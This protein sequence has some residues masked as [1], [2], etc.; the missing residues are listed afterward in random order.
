MKWQI[1]RYI[2]D[3]TR[4]TLRDNIK[5]GKI[6]PENKLCKPKTDKPQEIANVG[7]KVRKMKQS[8]T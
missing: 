2:H 4:E 5:A 7:Y 3:Y 8:T 1:N 6:I